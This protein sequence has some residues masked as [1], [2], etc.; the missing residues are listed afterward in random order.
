MRARLEDQH[1]RTRQQPSLKS[2]LHPK[3]AT[4]KRISTRAVNEETRLTIVSSMTP[5]ERV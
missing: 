3:E 1:L 4:R 2:K 5:R